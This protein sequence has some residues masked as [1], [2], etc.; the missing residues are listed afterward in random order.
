MS[1][2][3]EVNGQCLCGAVNLTAEVSTPQVDVCHCSMCRQWGGMPFV[4]LD[5]GD[6]LRIEGRDAV[7]SYASSDWAERGFCAH[8]GTHL[9]YLFV[10]KGAYHVP[11]GLFDV[12]DGVLGMGTQIFIDQK[13]D[14]YDFAQQTKTLT[15]AEVLVHFADDIENL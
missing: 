2:P 9:Y 6:A 1:T 13:P 14:Y 3:L 4:S 15:R 7:V 11:A 10:P 8:C 5:C 12:A